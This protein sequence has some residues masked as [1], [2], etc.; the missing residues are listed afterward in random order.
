MKLVIGAKHRFKS[1]FNLIQIKVLFFAEAGL[2]SERNP[3]KIF[4]RKG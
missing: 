2:D 4:G 1:E 3:V